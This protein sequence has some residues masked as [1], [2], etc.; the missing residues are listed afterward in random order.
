MKR[1]STEEAMVHS[2]GEILPFDVFMKLVEETKLHEKHIHGLNKQIDFIENKMKEGSIYLEKQTSIPL[3]GSI[4][5][6]YKYHANPFF[7]HTYY[8]PLTNSLCLDFNQ[9]LSGED[10]KYEIYKL[11]QKLHEDTKRRDGV[12]QDEETQKK[13][14][15]KF[16]KDILVPLKLYQQFLNL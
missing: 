15:I 2:C 1:Y 5:T 7:S 8:C 13:I 4:S 12:I 10:T 11:Q 6:H 16:L 3:T 9:N 14:F